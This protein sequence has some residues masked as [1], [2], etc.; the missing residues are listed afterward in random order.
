M[1][2]ERDW[3]TVYL[4]A[5]N[6]K[7]VSLRSS[8]QRGIGVTLAILFAVLVGAVAP[9]I[10]A[11]TFPPPSTMTTCQVGVETCGQCIC[12]C[13]PIFAPHYCYKADPATFKGTPYEGKELPCLTCPFDEAPPP[14]AR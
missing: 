6:P 12:H 5:A 13:Q 3:D 14:S 2:Q 1:S 7:G 11:C 10:I 9:A 4:T 8:I